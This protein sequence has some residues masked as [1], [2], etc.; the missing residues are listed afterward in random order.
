MN[1]YKK[2]QAQIV[3]KYWI[4]IDAR[5]WNYVMSIYYS[6]YGRSD[7]YLETEGIDDLEVVN[8]HQFRKE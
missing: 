4:H 2:D 6:Q 1:E 8:V 3:H 7:W 5:R